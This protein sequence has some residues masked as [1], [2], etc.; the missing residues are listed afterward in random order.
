LREGKEIIG[1]ELIDWNENRWNIE[2]SKTKEEYE[3]RKSEMEYTLAMND[4]YRLIIINK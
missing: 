4:V 2:E 1:E 3:I